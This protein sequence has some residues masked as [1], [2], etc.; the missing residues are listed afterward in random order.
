MPSASLMM[1]AESDSGRS[2]CAS[3]VDEESGASFAAAA[4]EVGSEEVGW[5]EDEASFVT[6]R[7]RVWLMRVERP[8][9]ACLFAVS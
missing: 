6:E 7:V 9:V 1:S 4:A 2:G 5:V 8:V 3:T